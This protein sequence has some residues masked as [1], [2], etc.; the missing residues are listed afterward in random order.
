MDLE[1]VDNLIK[2]CPTKEEMELIKGFK[3]DK[4]LLGKC[5]LFFME[6]MK[7]PRSEAK[8]RVFS[9]KLQFSTQVSDLSR[10]LNYVF[11]SVEQAS[12]IFYINLEVI[13]SVTVRSSVKLRR[14]MQT[15]L[16]LGNALNQGTARG[17][18]L[19]DLLY[20]FVEL[21]SINIIC[22]FVKIYKMI[23]IR[24]MC[25]GNIILVWFHDNKRIY[26]DRIERTIE[27]LIVLVPRYVP[28]NRLIYIRN[29]NGCEGGSVLAGVTAI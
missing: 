20:L 27:W 3:G 7:V 6:L 28:G 24:L 2:F 4:E 26:N 17:E 12:Y 11:L 16:S 29:R 19:F 22:R 5:E 13:L 8:L 9:Y 18:L 25:S 15:I 1:R 21:F 10:S 23:A 14:V